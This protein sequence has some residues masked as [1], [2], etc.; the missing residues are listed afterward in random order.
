MRH[1][2]EGYIRENLEHTPKNSNYTLNTN[3]VHR[4]FLFCIQNV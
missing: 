2:G 4:L 1:A 3:K